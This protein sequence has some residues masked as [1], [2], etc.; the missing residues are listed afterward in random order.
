[1]KK[2]K[3]QNGFAFTK[4]NY[5][6]LIT[7]LLIIVL[8][9]A[10]MIGPGTTETHFEEDIFSVRRITVAPVLSFLG[11]IFL[12]FAIMYKGKRDK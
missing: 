9:F 6:L 2:D 11:F 1:M 7:G 12:I 8:G 4:T 5:V 10:L 3:V